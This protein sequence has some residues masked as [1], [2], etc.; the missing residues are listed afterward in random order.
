[1]TAAIAEAPRILAPGPLRRL[2]IAAAGV[3]A[4]LL[5]AT[6]HVL[7]HAGPLAGAALFAGVGG[8]L[9]FGALGLHC[10]NPAAAEDAATHRVVA[11]PGGRARAVPALF[12]L[13][14]FVVA[15]A[16]TG[17]KDDNGQPSPATS[18]QPSDGE[19]D[20]HHPSPG[21]TE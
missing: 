4:A 8:T 16:L 20:V 1:M 17:A 18:P 3:G 9:L 12:A 6:P 7:H 21:S 13:S 10:R 14:S 11:A 5:G 2:R 15:P 19:H